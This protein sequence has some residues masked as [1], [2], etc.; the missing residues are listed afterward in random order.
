MIVVG[1]G[2]G[3]GSGKT[4][5]CSRIQD[6]LPDK[7]LI[8]S[9]DRYYKPFKDKD[10]FERKQINFDLPE[11]LDW[12]LMKQHIRRLRN[13]E[14][15]MIPQYSFE[16]NTR[17]GYTE[18]EPRE[19]ILIEGIHALHDEELNH[20]MDLKV[21]LNP[22]SDVRAVRRMKRDIVERN[23]NPEFAARQYLEKTKHA[24]HEHVEPTKDRAD[25]VL[26][27]DE[28]NKFI[29]TVTQKFRRDEASGTENLHEFVKEE[30]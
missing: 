2:G 4:Y 21:F 10:E 25:L 26:D 18:K 12:E 14:K 5:L 30:I 1:I 11:T 23:R 3:S 22:D 27:T 6:K 8:F 29:D 28:A 7:T 24:H 13:E 9:M 16:K 19:I 20:M 17:T 15:V